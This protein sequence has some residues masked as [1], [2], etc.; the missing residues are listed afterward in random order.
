VYRNR[1]GGPDGRTPTLAFEVEPANRPHRGSD[2]SVGDNMIV[3]GVVEGPGELRVY[4]DTGV[5]QARCTVPAADCSVDRSGTRTTLRLTMRPRVPGA[6]HAVLFAAP[7]DGPS[8]GLDA[9][10]E[11]AGRAGITLTSRDVPVH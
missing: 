5:E 2:P 3:R 8:Q 6:L 1:G 9:D 11:A 7:L 4:D 10:V